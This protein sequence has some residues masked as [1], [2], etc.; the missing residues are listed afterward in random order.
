MRFKPTWKV[1]CAIFFFFSQ[2][3]RCDSQ[4]P[5]TVIFTVCAS[6]LKWGWKALSR[7]KEGRKGHQES[8]KKRERKRNNGRF[9]FFLLNSDT[10]KL[11]V[12]GCPFSLAEAWRQTEML[13]QLQRKSMKMLFGSPFAILHGWYPSLSS[14]DSFTFV[15]SGGGWH[16]AAVKN[17]NGNHLYFLP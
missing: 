10:G 1:K 11:C 8:R 9:F 2:S 16:I 12:H 4:V 6:V 13:C 17:R 15:L 14:T 3:H 7:E 5:H